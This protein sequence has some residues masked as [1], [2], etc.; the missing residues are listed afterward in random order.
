MS[1]TTSTDYRHPHRPRAVALANTLGRRLE[2]VHV[3]A[4]LDP[5]ALLQA[6]RRRTGLAEFG[7][8]SFHEPLRQLVRSIES[9]A[10]LNPVGRLIT[11]E[12]LIGVLINRLRIQRAITSDPGIAKRPLQPPVVITGLQRSGTTLLH[13]LLASDPRFRWLAS[14]EALS[15]APGP[16]IEARVRAAERAERALAYLAPDFFAIHPVEAHAPEEEV[17]LLDYAFRSTVPEATLRVPTYARWLEE[18]DQRPAYEYLAILLRVLSAQ[19][20][21]DKRW[22]L[23]TP[24]HLEWLDVLLEVFPGVRV[25]WSHRDPTTTLA[26][27]CSMIGHGR[28]VFSDD[29]DPHEIGRE[30]SRKVARM[31]ERAMKTR[32]TADR[33]SFCDVRYEALMQDPI[34][35]AR[36]IYDFLGEPFTPSTERRMRTTLAANPQHQHG[37]H[38]YRLSDFGLA[39]DELQERFASYRARLIDR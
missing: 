18:Q 7:D 38:E 12:R 14:W 22:L 8:A 13:R 29:I 30:W 11:R 9:E 28:G 1:R 15:P 32:E 35:E 17:L 25:V 37:R 26:S 6:A 21:A 19:R 33:S 3:R 24:H 5:D 2:R 34:G 4:S 36:R 23:K 16:S 20:G 39:P 31:V 10:R 27:F